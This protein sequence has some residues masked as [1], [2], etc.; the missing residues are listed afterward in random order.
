MTELDLK[1]AHLPQSSIDYLRQVMPSLNDEGVEAYD[2][3][4]WLDEVFA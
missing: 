1:V 3:E 2:Y 4:A